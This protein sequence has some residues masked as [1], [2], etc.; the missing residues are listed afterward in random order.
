VK[1]GTG[2]SKT[3]SWPT[4]TWNKGS[5]PTLQTAAGSVDVVS[6]IYDG[7]NYFGTY[8]IAG[9]TGPT[10]ATGATGVFSGTVDNLVGGYE[11]VATAIDWNKAYHDKT[12]TGDT[13]FTFSNAANNMTIVIALVGD[14]VDRTLTWPSGIKWAS[15]VAD[16]GTVKASKSNLYTFTQINSVVYGAVLKDMI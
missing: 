5:A 14:T 10:G 7:T 9:P 6:V 2:G 13:T 11:A 12:L 3:I 15:P 1:Q 16:Y 8:E 4:I